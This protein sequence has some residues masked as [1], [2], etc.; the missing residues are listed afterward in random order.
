[1]TTN[2]KTDFILFGPILI[3]VAMFL[4]CGAK[5][6][7]NQQ[8]DSDLGNQSLMTEGPLGVWSFKNDTNRC[9]A[10]GESKY[11]EGKA[12]ITARVASS[13][14]DGQEDIPMEKVTS[15]KTLLGSVVLNYKN[16]GGKWVF[17]KAEP[18]ELRAKPISPSAWKDTFVPIQLELCDHYEHKSK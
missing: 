3:C 1:M 9:F 18:K 12:E 15:I 2:K 17:E 14:M 13:Q 8:I 11:T 6:I 7:T 5:K 4:G 16:E 10:I